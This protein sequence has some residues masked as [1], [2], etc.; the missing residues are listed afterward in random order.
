MGDTFNVEVSPTCKSD[1]WW[2]IKAVITC[3][4]ALENT[5]PQL[6]DGEYK[7]TDECERLRVRFNGM[8]VGDAG[9]VPET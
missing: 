7:L 1:D 4:T 6:Y 3:N 5:N 9:V 2:D 8:G